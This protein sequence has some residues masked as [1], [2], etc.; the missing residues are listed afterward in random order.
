ME[1]VP[2]RPRVAAPAP[3]SITPPLPPIGGVLCREEGLAVAVATPDGMRP[4]CV[5]PRTVYAI[6]DRAVVL[7]G[8][9]GGVWCPLL[10]GRPLKRADE[11]ARL[12]RVL[13]LLLPVLGEDIMHDWS[14]DIV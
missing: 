6:S 5:A 10:S 13:V 8:S 11:A 9:G 12:R 1:A 2:S 3:Q 4:S 14:R 7:L